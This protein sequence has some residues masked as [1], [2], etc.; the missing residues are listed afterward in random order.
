MADERTTAFPVL[1]AASLADDDLVPFIDVSDTSV[2]ATGRNVG[3]EWGGADG[4]QTLLTAGAA[5]YTDAAVAAAIG[6]IPHLST[7]VIGPGTG[8]NVTASATLNTYGAWQP[9]IASTAAESDLM[10]VGVTAVG[11]NGVASEAIISIGLGGAGS[12]VEL[13]AYPVGGHVAPNIIAAI[14]FRI[15]AGERISARIK[16]L[17]VVSEVA[18]VGI[19]LYGT[20]HPASATEVDVIGADVT[21]TLRGTALPTT[22]TYVQLTASTARD[23]RALVLI[24]SRALTTTGANQVL[25]YTVGMGGSGAEVQL[26]QFVVRESTSEVL[27]PVEGGMAGLTIFQHIPAGTRL[28]VKLSVGRAMFDATLIGIPYA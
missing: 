20:A 24:P 10:S 22:N 4:V 23:Y 17:N 25:T 6:T 21:T 11:A 13:F 8:S 7:T 26:G 1:P 2:A 19:I 9:I 15:A 18:T 5:A 3:V 28:A 12:E 16:S 14:P 27:W